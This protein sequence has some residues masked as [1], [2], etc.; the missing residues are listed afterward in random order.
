MRTPNWGGVGD[1]RE[2]SR[3]RAPTR[4][5]AHLDGEC[6]VGIGAEA[7]APVAGAVMEAATCGGHTWVWSGPGSRTRPRHSRPLCLPSVPSPL[8][9]QEGSCGSRLESELSTW[10]CHHPWGRR[11]LCPH[12][13]PCP[14]QETSQDILTS[15]P[16][17]PPHPPRMGAHPSQGRKLLLA[18]ELG[19]PPCDAPCQ[20]GAV[21]KDPLCWSWQP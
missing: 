12:G 10:A 2:G 3:R 17:Y 5:G 19:L 8:S 16:Q 11:L 18:P 1:S 4:S 20:E 7:P 21:R 6:D 14:E 13:H 9:S 15:Q